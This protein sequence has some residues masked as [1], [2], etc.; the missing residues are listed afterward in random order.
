VNGAIEER[1]ELQRPHKV[2]LGEIVPAAE[3]QKAR[4]LER[5]VRIGRVI[6]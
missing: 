1:I 2:L 5:R 4:I 3:E 6:L